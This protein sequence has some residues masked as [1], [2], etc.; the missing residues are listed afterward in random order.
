MEPGHGDHRLHRGRCGVCR[1]RSHRGRD[2]PPGPR[3]HVDHRDVRGPGPDDRARRRAGQAGDRLRR[4]LVRSG[5]SDERNGRAG[6]HHPVPR[7][8]LHADAGGPITRARADLPGAGSTIPVPGSP[9]H[10]AG[11]RRGLGRP[12]CRPRVRSNGLSAPRC[13]RTRSGGHRFKPRVPAPGTTLLADRRCR[14]V[15]R[16]VQ[17]GVP[18]RV[19]AIRP[20]T[21]GP[22]PHVRPVRYPRPGRGPRRHARRRLSIPGT[23]RILHVVNAP[24]PA[25]TASMAI[26][27]EIANRADDRFGL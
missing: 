22:G 8:L 17:V 10:A 19:A 2:D 5:G 13:Q 1:R 7:R 14:D 3:G 25:A 23:D 16:L 20:G 9:L 15:A 24:S 6:T 26:A 18:G 21:P 4:A 27:E 11:R 12:E